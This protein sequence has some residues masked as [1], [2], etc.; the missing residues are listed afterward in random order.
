[1][2]NARVGK[3][4]FFCPY[5]CGKKYEALGGLIAHIQGKWK[6]T[7]KEKSIVKQHE[8]MKIE[9]GWYLD[10]W[11]EDKASP[12]LREYTKA[13][14]SSRTQ[15]DG[16]V[17]LSY[18]ERKARREAK[19]A[20][21]DPNGTAVLSEKDSN[22]QSA[23]SSPPKKRSKVKAMGDLGSKDLPVLE[24]TASIPSKQSLTL[25]D[26][27]TT[28]AISTTVSGS[29][30][31]TKKKKNSMPQHQKARNGDIRKFFT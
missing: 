24:S 9:D 8:A 15:A 3:T 23:V 31:E 14:N 16:Y 10:T 30:L 11:T 7:L 22:Q 28:L 5:G 12:E 19:Y 21:A 20:V 2:R 25:T 4:H 6:P 18:E 27:A 13:H 29:G 26:D 1:M 17:D